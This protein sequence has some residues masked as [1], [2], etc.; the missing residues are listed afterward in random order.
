L[1]SEEIAEKLE[2]N[3]PY[4]IRQKMPLTGIVSFND[5]VYGKISTPAEE[6]DDQIL[7]KTDGY[8]TYNFA[9][10]ID[11]HTMQITHVVRGNEYLSS[12][13]KYNLL[14]EAFGWEVPVYVHCAH[15]MKDKTTKYSKRN[16]DKSFEE[17]VEA[18]YLPQA[19]VNFTALLGWA[20]KGEN[21]IFSLQ[22]LI[23][24][25]SISGISK[26][27]AVFDTVKLTAMNGEYIRR[28]SLEEYVQH[29]VPYIQK[30]VK[31][32]DIDY[33]TLCMV[34]QPRTEVWTD[35]APQVDFI[36]VLPDYDIELYTHK[37]MKTNPENA[38]VALQDVQP[39]LEKLEDWTASGVHEA[40]FALIAEKEVK[41]GIILWPI[42]TALTGKPVT[43]GGGI[44]LCAVLGKKETL[45]RIAKGIQKLT[46]A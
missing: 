20:P 11:D 21:E 31:R 16:G 24:E 29:A 4:V 22:E 2:A 33:K 44:E 1:S 30:A 37:K 6:L 40:I 27:P 42:R 34:L 8:P 23:E 10:V 41:N 38:L 13:P 5:E 9:N 43:P 14:Y 18:G 15:V 36:D 25:F 17:L 7:I 28:M 39:V 46:Q 3:I 19:L 12:A 45:A 32:T 26:S 35:I